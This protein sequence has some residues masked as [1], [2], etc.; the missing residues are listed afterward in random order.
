M[1]GRT[2]QFTKGQLDALTASIAQGVLMFDHL[3]RRTTFRSI[4]DMLA[5]RDRMMRELDSADPN[6][7]TR[8]VANASVFLHR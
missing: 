2:S 6:L 4:K 7:P 5:L 1:R 3:G 8:P